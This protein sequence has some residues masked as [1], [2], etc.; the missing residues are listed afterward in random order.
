MAMRVSAPGKLILLGEHFVVH[1]C[2]AVAAAVEKRAVATALPHETVVIDAPDYSIRQEMTTGDVLSFLS[3]AQSLREK[4]D[5]ESLKRLGRD[6]LLPLKVVTGAAL[7]NCSGKGV[8]VRVTSDVPKA[9]GMG[10]GSAAFVSLAGAILTAH[11]REP[12][13]KTVADL[14]Y[15]GDVLCHGKPSGIDNNTVAFGGYLKFRK[16]S[17]PE[18]LK[19]SPKLHVVIGSTG[20]SAPTSDMVQ[21]NRDWLA[22][23]PARVDHLLEQAENISQRGL[24]ALKSSDAHALGA[25]ANEN[26]VILRELGVSHPFLEKLIIAARKAGALGAKLSGAGGGG[27]MYAICD[28]EDAQARVAEAIKTAGGKPIL[29]QLGAQGVRKE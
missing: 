28:G 21:I 19:V 11:G 29:T 23:E 5:V 15:V 9:S 24:D 22:L 10:S 27:I 8:N 18:P 7:A 17:G 2:L 3:E 13:A 25:L 1:D 14:A 6:P 4:E 26:Q 16:S 12:D 20:V